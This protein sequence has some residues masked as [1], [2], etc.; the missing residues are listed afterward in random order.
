MAFGWFCHVCGHFCTKISHCNRYKQIRIP[1]LK[2][3]HGIPNFGMPNFGFFVL[4]FTASA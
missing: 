3:K 2:E 4:F 1:N